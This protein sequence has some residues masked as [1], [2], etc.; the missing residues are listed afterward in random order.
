LFDAFVFVT[1]EYNHSVA[2]ALKNALD[3]VYA[4]WADKAAG[5]VS[6]GV[7]GGIRAVEHL[8]LIMAELQVAT[9]RTQ[10]TLNSY[11]DFENFY[12]FKP[13]GQH[14]KTLNT[15]LDQVVSRGTALQAVRQ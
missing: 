9:V 2:A 12:D 7:A 11:T 15:V 14:E 8:R 3:F 6:Y 1:P 13:T 5:F 4:E 10:L